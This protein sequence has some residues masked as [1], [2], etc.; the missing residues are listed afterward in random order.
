[1]MF[2]FGRMDVLIGLQIV[3]CMLK[4]KIQMGT[5]SQDL[6]RWDQD[7]LCECSRDDQ[8]RG[9]S[10]QSSDVLH[11]DHAKIDDEVLHEMIKSLINTE[12][13]VMYFKFRSFRSFSDI[14]SDILYFHFDR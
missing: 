1:M 8:I 12:V 4:G 13:G 11:I 3:N 9:W 7:L 5:P 14:F 2:G 6:R 10:I